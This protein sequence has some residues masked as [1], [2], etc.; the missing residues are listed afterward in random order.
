M[1]DFSHLPRLARS[2]GQEFVVTDKMVIGRL[3]ECQVQVKDGLASRRHA[4]LEIAGEKVT[5]TDLDSNNGTWV[6][7]QK[8][9][10][11]LEL[12]NGDRIRIAETTFVFKSPA[13]PQKEEEDSATNR[14][15]A[16]QTGSLM[17]LVR[18]S[19]GA[20]FGLSRNMRIG[21]DDTNDLPL[22]GDSSA[23]QFHAAVELLDGRVAIS[24]MN[25]NNGTWVNGK[26]IAGKTLLKHGDKI[27]MGNTVLRLRV[28]DLPLPPLDPT[29]APQSK[30]TSNVWMWVAVFLVVAGLLLVCVLTVPA[31]V[32]FTSRGSSPTAA[33]A[34]ATSDIPKIK[35]EALRSLA[36][37]LVPDQD[38]KTNGWS[39][40]SGS[41][42][43][44]QGYILTNF[45]VIGFTEGEAM[46]S[47]K[48]T[49]D[50]KNTLY[51]DQEFILAGINWSNPLAKPDT[52]YRCE[53][54]K[55]DPYLDLALLHVVEIYN[56][57]DDT[58]SPLPADL[59]FPFIPIGNS[60]NLKILEPITIIGFPGVGGETPTAIDDQVAGFSPDDNYNIENGWIKTGPVIS[61]GNSGGM[62]INQKGELIGIPTMIMYNDTDKIGYIRPIKLA[63][64]LIQEF[65]P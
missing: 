59:S 34:A 30:T 44:K 10:K 45:H 7:D 65:L 6:N 41:F 63:L 53:I 54:I 33:A 11:P 14:T 27:R 46:N 29:A 56:M 19:D 22:K 62:A 40:G 50:L 9:T 28:G 43:N 2:D 61:S 18:G 25:S 39:T 35:Q 31:A 23:S 36:Y 16:W 5:L 51:K 4:M 26:R 57:E 24:D 47:G 13:Q 15:M 3:P 20:E 32:I 48:N 12:H 21:R 55:T 42:I 1:N 8:V 60:D 38:Y 17:T 64:S 58:V 52:Y 49:G 37:I